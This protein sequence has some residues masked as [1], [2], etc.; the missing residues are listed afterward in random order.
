MPSVSISLV[1][2]QTERTRPPRALWV[3]FELGRPFGPPSDPEFQTRVVLAALRLLESPN[4]PVL[5]EDF[6]EDDPRE[7]SDPGWSAPNGSPAARG[8][9]A[10]VRADRLITEIRRLRPQYL[11]VVEQRSGRTSVGLSGLSVADAAHYVSEHLRGKPVSSPSPDI[12]SALALRFAVDD[13]KAYYT[14]A[15]S[16]GTTKPSSRQVGDWFWNRTVA[17]AAIFELRK[18]NLASEDEKLKLIATMFLV[19]GARVPP[20]E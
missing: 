16:A 17:G 7:K 5:L 2:P 20:A 10:E 3:P 12:S 1:R 13:L 15:A 6:P 4:G 8:E 9:L 18:M 14:E 11:Q 19:P